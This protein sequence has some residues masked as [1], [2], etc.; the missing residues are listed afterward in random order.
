LLKAAPVLIMKSATLLFLLAAACPQPAF[1]NSWKPT[2]TAN[3]LA[4]KGGDAAVKTHSSFSFGGAQQAD[5]PQRLSDDV[6]T[7]LKELRA[8]KDDPT[9]NKIFHSALR[10]TFAVTW[11][12]EMW[13]KHTSRWRFVNIFLFWFH[14][15][16]LKR[17]MPQMIGLMVWTYA[18]IQIMEKNQSVF[19]TVEFP[20]TSLSLV[21]G[22]VASLLALRSN[23]GLSRLMEARLYF[24]KVVL[25]CRDMASLMRHF[26][27]NGNPELALKM[28]RHLALFPWLLKNF[29]RG[30]KVTGTDEDI[31]RTMVPKADADYILSQRK[32]PVAVVM[33]LRQALAH[34]SHEKALTTAEEMAIDHTIQ[35]MDTVIMLCERLVASPI[36]PLFTTHAARLLVFYLFFLP[37]ALKKTGSLNAS[38]IYATVAAVGFAMLGLDEISHLMEQPFKITPM[39]HL[40]RNAMRDVAD[41]FC[42]PIPSLSDSKNSGYEV[43]TPRPYWGNQVGLESD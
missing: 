43:H 14:S 29:L 13:E 32:M 34:L 30:R 11:T 6:T 33:R 19:A 24:G 16:L 18:A 23:Q 27:N 21:S 35:S 41:A 5:S 31:I 17:V 12:H 40:C 26:V 8:E 15:A 4:V 2:T 20:M 25:Y 38:G 9:V 28:A 37:I 39:Y 3:S 7:V 36:P 22:F 1:A 42:V 10:P